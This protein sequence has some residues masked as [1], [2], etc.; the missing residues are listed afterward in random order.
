MSPSRLTAILVVCALLAPAVGMAQTLTCAAAEMGCCC[1]EPA[2]VTEPAGPAIDGR[3]CCDL[4]RDRPLVEAAPT[5]AIAPDLSV[6]V[7]PPVAALA[8]LAVI[9]PG[10]IRVPEPRGPPPRQ[11]LLSQRTSLLR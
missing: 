8:D 5:V 10:S 11:T 3:C 9:S 2:A 7:E 4:D 1:P 6:G